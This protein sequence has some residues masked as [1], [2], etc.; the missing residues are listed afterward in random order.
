MKAQ[1]MKD[2]ILSLLDDVCFSYNGDAVCINPWS[3]NKIEVGY[4]KKTKTYTSIDALMADKIFDGKSLT[5][6]CPHITA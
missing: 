5:D 3:A 2:R 1:D 4:R 6:I